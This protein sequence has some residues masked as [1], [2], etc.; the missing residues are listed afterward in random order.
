MSIGGCRAG[1]LPRY[2][3]VA[4]RALVIW[5]FMPA[6]SQRI[7]ASIMRMSVRMHVDNGLTQLATQARG[8]RIQSA[9]A[10]EGPE[11]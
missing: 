6:R 10:H 1:G 8:A 3:I 4:M 2:Q 7:S 9:T 5:K 11:K